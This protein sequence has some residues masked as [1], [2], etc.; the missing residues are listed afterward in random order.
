MCSWE[1]IKDFKVPLPIK[2]DGEMDFL[3]MQNFISAVQK[4]V[5]KD[6]VL[7]VDKKIATTKEVIKKQTLESMSA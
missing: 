7:Y 1:K 5:I 6:V 2:D 4:L 3:F